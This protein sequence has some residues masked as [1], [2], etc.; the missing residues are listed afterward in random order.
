MSVTFLNYTI[1][2]TLHR[3][4]QKICFRLFRLL[5]SLVSSNGNGSGLLWEPHLYRLSDYHTIYKL[6][7]G[8][9]SPLVQHLCGPFLSSPQVHERQYG[10]AKCT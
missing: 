8:P 7:A 2:C 6:H 9:Y 4:S 10:I 3:D 5:V 1:K